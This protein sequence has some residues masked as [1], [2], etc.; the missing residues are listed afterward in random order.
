MRLA[1]FVPNWIGDVVMATPALAALRAHFA[2]AEMVGV[3]KPYVAGVLAGSRVFDRLIFSGGASLGGVARD[4]ARLR[5]QAIDVAVLMT[6]S[7]R[8]A[9]VAWAGGC[10]RIVG[11]HRDGRGW[12]LTDRLPSL[13]DTH[14]RFLPSPVID[15]Y[16]QLAT[17]L[18]CPDPG[19]RMALFTTPEDEAH[20]D[21]VW[22]HLG[23]DRATEVVLLNPG[24]AFGSSKLWPPGHFA[25]V[26]CRLCERPGCRVLVLCGP[27]ERGLARE[28]ASRAACPKVASLADE[29]PS[30]GLLK[31]C[32]RRA[33]L[34]ITT[35]SGPRHFAAAFDRPVIT[36]FGPTHIAWTETY[37]A[38]AIHL[39]KRM[40]CGPCQLRTCPLDHA[41]MRDLTPEEVMDAVVTLL[42]TSTPTV[43]RRAS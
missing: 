38:K 29:V 13:R 18:G 10:R 19:Y 32:V 27:N 23:L 9:C 37:H 35:D 21:R 24:A 26:A 7:F 43:R 14:G 3:L 28:I 31:A 36:L 16:N 30:L 11:Y 20:A 40:P 6:N 33:S 1:V 42:P 5:Q 22:R 4:V 25:E 12:L 41:C 2:Q 15:S 39:Q 34:L 8:S 17:H